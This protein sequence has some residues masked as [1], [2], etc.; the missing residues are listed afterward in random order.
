MTLGAFGFLIGYW[1]CFFLILLKKPVVKPVGR[2]SVDLQVILALGV[3]VTV[4]LL[5]SRL[6]VATLKPLLLALMEFTFIKTDF[7]SILLERKHWL[8]EYF[9]SILFYYVSSIVF[10]LLIPAWFLQTNKFFNWALL[11][12]KRLRK[13]EPAAATFLQMAAWAFIAIYI[14]VVQF[15]LVGDTRHGIGSF[16]GYFFL[17][18][19]P[20]AVFLFCSV[21]VAAHYTEQMRIEPWKGYQK[22]LS[23]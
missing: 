12:T 7:Q 4:S 11:M 19:Y 9:F 20:F 22:S 17:A 15:G 6:G 2:L 16:K 21:I 18:T 10:C 1:M 13:K 5:I 3:V 14:L 8:R 23:E